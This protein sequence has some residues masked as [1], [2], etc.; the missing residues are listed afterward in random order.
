MAYR[1]WKPKLHIINIFRENQ[2]TSR[3][4][5]INASIQDVAKNTFLGLRKHSD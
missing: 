4:T 5:E 1:G 3:I 2:N